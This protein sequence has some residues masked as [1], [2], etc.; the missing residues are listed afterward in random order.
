MAV[1]DLK[2]QLEAQTDHQILSSF[3]Q[4]ILEDRKRKAVFLIYLAEVDRRKIFGFETYA[5]DGASEAVSVS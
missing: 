4:M 3:T 2:R 1:Q 5:S